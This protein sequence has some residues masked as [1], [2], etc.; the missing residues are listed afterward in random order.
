MT[1]VATNLGDNEGIN[2]LV[3]DPGPPPPACGQGV[4]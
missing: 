3:T 2:A 4:G 1:A